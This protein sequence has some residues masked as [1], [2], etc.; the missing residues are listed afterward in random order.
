MS[1][2][3]KAIKDNYIGIINYWDFN[4]SYMFLN[5]EL[6]IIEPLK[7]LDEVEIIDVDTFTKLYT[8]RNVK[9]GNEREKQYG[10]VWE[11]Y[12]KIMSYGTTQ[13]GK[14]SKD[15]ARHLASIKARI[16]AYKEMAQK[17]DGPPVSPDGAYDSELI[18]RHEIGPK[19]TYSVMCGKMFKEELTE[20]EI[21][22]II[23]QYKILPEEWRKPGHMISEE[24]DA[25]LKEE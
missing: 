13:T 16:E 15:F 3:S 23:A 20:D 18:E 21:K 8:E 7:S 4:K 11:S 1:H 19:S 5:F 22:Q 25:F 9:E 17:K 6:G 14:W 12:L 10:K 24:M 2:N